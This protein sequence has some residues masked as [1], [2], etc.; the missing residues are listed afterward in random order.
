MAI[1]SQG[2]FTQGATAS[3]IRIPLVSDVDRFYVYNITQMAANQ[4]TAVGVQYYW[5]RG[6]PAGAMIEYLKSNAANANN[7]IQY[8]TSGGFTLI[9]TTDQQPGVLNN[10]STGISAITAANP[11]VVTVGSTAGMAPGSIVRL[12]N[13][14]G[15]TQYGGMD[16]TVGYN[17]FAGGNT[18]DLSYAGANAN[19]GS[20]GSFR[21]IPY[22]P[23][24]YPRTRFITSIS[25]AAQAV[26]RTSVTHGLQRG[27]KVSF[28]VPPIFG[29]VQ[30]DG[31]TGTVVAVDTTNTVNTFTVDI[32]SSAFTA[33]AFPANGNQ[34]FSPAVV[35]PAGEDNAYAVDNSLNPY[36]SAYT[37]VGYIGI[38]LAAGANSPA[39]TANDVIYWVAEKADSVNTI[40]P[41]SLS[42]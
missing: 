28:K 1:I 40:N 3:V 12:Y 11:P 31:L 37:N 23:I 42:L 22:N 36:V 8:A 41:V 24:F 10:G 15:A 19:A 7:L 4:T 13:T 25:Q 34:P 26:V 20:A 29:M 27:M 39:G 14:T 33:F 16:W 30:M 35:V 6:F 2:T 18:F 32:D 9:N 38:Q 17:T 21:V 5:Q